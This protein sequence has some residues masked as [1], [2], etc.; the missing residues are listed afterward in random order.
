MLRII[1]QGLRV[2]V[3]H[4]AENIDACVEFTRDY[5]VVRRLTRLPLGWQGQGRRCA[6]CGSLNL[7]GALITETADDL[8]PNILC[9]DCL[10]WWD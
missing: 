2:T 9:L 3:G 4:C 5:R 8:D 10:D 6:F 7:T 1:E